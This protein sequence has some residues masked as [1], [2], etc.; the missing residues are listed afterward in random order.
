MQMEMNCPR[1]RKGERII[2]VGVRKLAKG[3]VQKFLCRNCGRYFSSS[4]HP[5]SLYPD[6]LMI[7]SFDLYNR[8]MA[9]AD[10][11]SHMKE[12]YTFDIPERT[13]YSWLQRYNRRY[14]LYLLDHVKNGDTSDPLIIVRSP[15]HHGMNVTYH[16]SK[17]ESITCKDIE[18]MRFLDRIDPG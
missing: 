10:I 4:I 18:I 11:I 5:F 7:R 9:V 8:G 16:R 17:V 14:D 12:K 6:D 3:P 1:C 15:Y 2:K 13:V